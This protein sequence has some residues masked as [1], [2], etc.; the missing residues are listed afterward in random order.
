MPAQNSFTSWSDPEVERTILDSISIDQPWELVEE[1]VKHIRLSGTDEERMAFDA[2]M[3]RLDGWGVPYTLHEPMAF[4]SHPLAATVRTLGPDGKAFRAKTVA[5]SVSTDGAEIEGQLVYV[6]GKAGT[7]YKA[8][9]IFAAG[10]DVGESGIAGKIVITE[11]M[12]AP[13][14]V[15]DLIKGGALAGVFVNPGP[16][17]HEGICTTIWGTPDLYNQQNQPSIPAIAVN[18]P[19][20]LALIEHAISGGSVALSTTLET[21]WRQIPIL[22]A[23]V[24]GSVEPDKYVL[25][26]GHVDGW[27]YGAGDNA[28]GDATIAEIA[29]VFNEHKDLLKRSIKLA[30][31]SGHSH[32]RYAG[33]TW[34]ADAFGIDLANNCLAQV[35]CDSPGCRWAVT[36]NNLT[37]F[38]EAVDFV[39]QVIPD[40]T[41]ITPDPDR[42]IRAGDY[43][44]NNIG[45]TG[46]Y[47]LSSTMTDEDRAE[48][49]YYPVGGCG[50][51]IQWH[52]EDDLM[53]ILDKEILLRDI[54]MYAASVLRVMNAPVVP[55]NF[56][57]AT[58]DIREALDRY[59]AAAEGFF[60]F[61]P[62]Y[63]ALESLESALD[64]FYAGIPADIAAESPEAAR[65]NAAQLRL[66]RILIPINF[67]RAESFFHDPALSVPALPNLAPALAAKEA[68]GD[69]A[70][71]GVLRATLTRGQNKVIWALQMAREAVA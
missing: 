66:A 21:G 52:T 8:G 33:S 31:W 59:Q 70:S 25:L 17:I 18:N 62:T 32:G 29:R 12:A 47:M 41:G 36:Y 65:L 71:A 53:F 20:G 64:A 2:I 30:W 50:A 40:T 1:I 54:R 60:D 42:P 37:T 6:P 63:Q 57:G 48:K 44:F 27:H 68:A 61:G 23:D 39:N 55:F 45:I 19:D 67:T 13:G 16:F 58:K 9:D 51:N 46:F 26:H 38:P 14:K 15:A 5:M 11:G 4:I 22:V 56:R 69:Q 43:S 28:T 7:G 24:K 10:V 35:N 49:G 34:F 3:E